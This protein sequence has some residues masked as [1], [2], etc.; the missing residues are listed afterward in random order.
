VNGAAVIMVQLSVEDLAKLIRKEVREALAA[1][2]QQAQQPA[3]S[4]TAKETAEVLKIPAHR[5]R[6]LARSGALPSFKIGTTVRFDV[7][8]VE[9]FKAANRSKT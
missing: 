7:A 4:L 8:G 6:E 2:A 1:N 5:V 3:S 9:A